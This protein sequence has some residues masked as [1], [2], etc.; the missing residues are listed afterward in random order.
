MPNVHPRLD[1]SGTTLERERMPSDCPCT[2]SLSAYSKTLSI[3]N[4]FLLFNPKGAGASFISREL[5]KYFAR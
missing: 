2:R 3:Q 4:L 1:G 5:D